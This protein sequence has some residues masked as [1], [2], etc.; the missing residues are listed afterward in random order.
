MTAACQASVSFTISLNLLKLMSIEASLVAQM[1][2]HL[3]AMQETRVWSLGQEDSLE[4]EMATHSSTLAWKIPW[5]EEPGRLQS[6]ELQRVRHDWATSPSPCPLSQWCH[7]TISSSVLPYSSCPQSFPASGSFPVYWLFP[8]GDQTVGALTSAS[9]L[10]MNSQG[11]YPLGMTGLIT[12][13]P[14]GLKSLLQHH[15]SKASILSHS[16][17]FLVTPIYDYWKNHDF[18]YTDLY[19]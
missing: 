9:V 8:S 13:P 5:M 17:F 1:V 12:L 3:P 16:A 6:M 7:P 18:D 14:K 11:W 19:Q 15:S 4:K 10:P 2:K